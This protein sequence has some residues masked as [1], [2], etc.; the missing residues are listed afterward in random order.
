M[1]E[2]EVV[3]ADKKMRCWITEHINENQVANV[4]TEG[5]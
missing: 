5:Q 1:E 3:T 4:S 2:I